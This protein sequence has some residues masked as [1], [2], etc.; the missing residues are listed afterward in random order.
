MATLDPAKR[1][2]NDVFDENYFVGLYR[3]SADPWGIGSH[4]YELRKRALLLAA[5]PERRYQRGFEPGCA[6]GEL[7]ALLAGRCDALLAVD[8]V[9][10]AVSRTAARVAGHAH[11][12]T[13]RMA[14]PEEWPEG[15]FDLIV[16]SELAYYLDETAL[17]RLVAHIERSLMDGGTL[18]SCH[19]KHPI[20]GAA[21][22]GE[23]LHARMEV[24]LA[25]RRLARYEDGDFLLDV[26]STNAQSVAQREGVR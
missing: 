22:A 26:W 13:R 7:T 10:D 1:L 21:F 17:A 11:V 3:S 20:A 14:V 15:R 8:F 9:E 2:N 12:L 4:W 16:V 24:L 18:V 5:L 25:L 6:N 23:G 19:W